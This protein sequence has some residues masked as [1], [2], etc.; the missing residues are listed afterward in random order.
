MELLGGYLEPLK[1]ARPSGIELVFRSETLAGDEVSVEIA[2]G[3]AGETYHRVFSP[4]GGDHVIAV[5]TK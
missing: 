3:A 4:G 2:E 5:T 1:A